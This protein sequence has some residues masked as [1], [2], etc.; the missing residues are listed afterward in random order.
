MAG[1]GSLL[2]KFRRTKEENERRA[3]EEE[4]SQHEEIKVE[5]AVPAVGRGRGGI[6]LSKFGPKPKPELNPEPRPDRSSE[7]TLSASDSASDVI[8]T[9]S[10]T[11]VSSSTSQ[12]IAGVGRGKHLMNLLNK[13][14]YKIIQPKQ[15]SNLF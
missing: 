13:T 7:V 5:Q 6:L 15:S 14:R 2:D 10:A 12:S 11:G 9:S 1:R 4:E 8:S 3:K